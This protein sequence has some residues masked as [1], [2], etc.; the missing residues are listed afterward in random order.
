MVNVLALYSDD[1]S[2]NPAEVYSFESV[3]LLEKNENKRK[4]CLV[5]WPIA[6]LCLNTPIVFKKWADP[7][8]FLFIFVLFTMQFK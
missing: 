4:R 8:L 6:N 2:A 1:P 7:G 3:Q 5:G